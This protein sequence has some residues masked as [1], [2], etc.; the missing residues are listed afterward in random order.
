MIGKVGPSRACRIATT[1]D[2]L[3]LSLAPAAPR[4][5][6]GYAAIVVALSPALN[7]SWRCAPWSLGET[8][9]TRTPDTLSVRLVWSGGS[10][11]R[12]IDNPCSRSQRSRAVRRLLL[13]TS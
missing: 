12:A 5:R 7:R 4:W 8:A 9:D 2:G 1:V 6:A 11:S 3:D 10:A 13:A